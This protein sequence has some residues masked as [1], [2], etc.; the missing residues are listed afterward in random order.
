MTGRDPE[1]MGRALR[2]VVPRAE[3]PA[4]L[5][6]RAFRAAMA[7]APD[8]FTARF[9]VSARRFALAGAIASALVWGGL[10]LRGPA[11]AE[12][13]TSAAVSAQLDPA[14]AALSLWAGEEIAL[15]E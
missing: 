15:G 3:V 11:A 1:E 8:P 10:I 4:G 6:D 14:E 12:P 7:A 2:Q 9:V 5:A 13:T